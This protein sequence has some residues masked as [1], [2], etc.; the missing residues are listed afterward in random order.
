MGHQ[1]SKTLVILSQNLLRLMEGHATLKNDSQLAKP[2]KMDQKTIWRI[3]NKMN[4]PSIDKVEKLAKAFGV[5]PWE[6]LVPGLDPEH[7]PTLTTK[8]E[9]HS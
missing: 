7:R 9:A 2:A 5:E 3:V 4:E 1:P 6:L 8:E